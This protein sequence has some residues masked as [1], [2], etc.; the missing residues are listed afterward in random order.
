MLLQEKAM[1]LQEMAGGAKANVRGKR[2]HV[3]NIGFYSILVCAGQFARGQ[4][5]MS[6]GRLSDSHST[7]ISSD[8]VVW[9]GF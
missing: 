2:G 6:A 1:L 9:R 7:P 8:I 4:K 3:K 5:Q